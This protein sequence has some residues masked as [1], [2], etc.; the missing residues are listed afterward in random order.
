MG[1]I[2]LSAKLKFSTRGSGIRRWDFA[3]RLDCAA[4]R[5]FLEWTFVTFSSFNKTIG[6]KETQIKDAYEKTYNLLL[7]GG[8]NLFRFC[9]KLRGR[10]ETSR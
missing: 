4:L 3:E 5:R 8:R 10:T 9:F 2:R 1:N 7:G 6:S